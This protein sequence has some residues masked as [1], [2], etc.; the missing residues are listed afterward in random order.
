MSISFRDGYYKEGQYLLSLLPKETIEYLSLLPINAREHAIAFK[1]NVCKW[2]W[3][4]NSIVENIFSV[5]ESVRK[6]NPENLKDELYSLVE[7]FEKLPESQKREV[8]QKVSLP[9][10]F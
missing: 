4:A 9:A 6:R 8:E 5:V 2:D 7:L 10:I 3:G 1:K